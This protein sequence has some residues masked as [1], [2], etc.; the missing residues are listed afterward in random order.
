VALQPGAGYYFSRPLPPERFLEL[1]QERRPASEP[2][3]D[4]IVPIGSTLRAPLQAP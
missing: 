4:A 1:L 2:T 3:D